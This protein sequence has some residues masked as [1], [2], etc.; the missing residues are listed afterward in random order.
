MNNCISKI[1]A[2]LTAAITVCMAYSTAHAATLTW[3]GGAQ[4]SESWENPTNWS[5]HCEPQSGMDSVTLNPA[6]DSL[7]NKLN[8]RSQLWLNKTFLIGEGQQMTSA[9]QS[10]GVLRIDDGGH[11]IIA[12]GGTL[13]FATHGAF[14]LA[15]GRGKMR[16]TVEA[17][18]NVKV[19]GLYNG[20]H[21]DH[22]IQFIADAHGVSPIEVKYAAYINGGRLEID[23]DNYDLRNGSELVL[24]TQL[25]SVRETT[26]FNEVTL[27][28]GWTGTI[29]YNYITSDGRTAIALTHLQKTS[30]PVSIPEPSAFGLIL[31]AITAAMTLTSRR[32]LPNRRNFAHFKT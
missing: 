28:S 8:Q 31:S 4:D 23:L 3:S 20:T 15:E 7:G 29:D 18:A 21:K 13:D 6:V 32:T 19:S 9:D 25:M 11:L 26:T 27:S 22:T 10:N 1:T 14:D 12:R 16:L 5:N 17:G 24:I 30:E 2:T